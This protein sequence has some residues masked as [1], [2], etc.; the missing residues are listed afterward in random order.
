MVT[1][2]DI[3]EQRW[4]W[5]ACAD[6]QA[7]PVLFAYGTMSHYLFTGPAFVIFFFTRLGGLGSGFSTPSETGVKDL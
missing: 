7:D 2:E 4:L 1:I 3:N 6:E 5:S